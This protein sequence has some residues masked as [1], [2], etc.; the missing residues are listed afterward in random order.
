MAPLA[1]EL[2]F[3][4]ATEEIFPPGFS[5]SVDVRGVT[6]QWEGAIRPGHFRGVATVVLKLFHIVPADR[7]YFG[8]KDYQQLLTI[9]RMVSDLNLPIQIVACPLVRD[10][11]GLAMSSRNAYLSADE[12]RQALV[13]SRSLRLAAKCSPPASATTHKIRDAVRDAIAAEPGVQ[14]EYVGVVDSNSLKE[15]RRIDSS[16]VVLL[17]ARVGKTRLIDNELLGDAASV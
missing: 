6:R 10:A 16:A 8:R 7:A 5:T 15:L 14:I 12:R 17:A 11:D 9:Q 13:L 3:T 4:P 2:V 1:V